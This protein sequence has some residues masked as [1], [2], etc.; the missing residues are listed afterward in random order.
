MIDANNLPDGNEPERPAESMDALLRELGSELPISVDW[1]VYE[2]TLMSRLAGTQRAARWKSWRAAAVGSIAGAAAMFLLSYSL[3]RPQNP[4]GDSVL[5]NPGASRENPAP[6]QSTRKEPVE[7]PAPKTDEPAPS[8]SSSGGSYAR[9]SRGSDGQS[10]GIVCDNYHPNEPVKPF[11][12]RSPHKNG[13]TGEIR[14]QGF[15]EGDGEPSVIAV[16]S[17]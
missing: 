3:L 13:R 10:A 14:F 15:S 17:K 5:P 2:R 8:T 9:L 12:R 4:A 6:P 11:T 1:E 16:T 7:T